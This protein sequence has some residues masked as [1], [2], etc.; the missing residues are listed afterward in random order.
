MKLIQQKRTAKDNRGCEFEYT[1]YKALDYKFVGIGN[2]D[3]F[4]HADDRSAFKRVTVE[5][6]YEDNMGFGLKAETLEEL[7][8]KISQIG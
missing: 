6:L 2:G 7:K 8:A 5:S 3:K 1:L 4:K